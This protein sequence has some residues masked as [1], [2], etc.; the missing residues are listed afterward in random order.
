MDGCCAHSWHV[1]HGAPH[2]H[3]AHVPRCA[4]ATAVS[5]DS[6]C[7]DLLADCTA[8]VA[9]ACTEHAVHDDASGQDAVYVVVTDV[10]CVREAK[11]TAVLLR[12][13]HCVHEQRHTGVQQHCRWH[14]C[15]SAVCPR[16]AP[17]CEW[18]SDTSGI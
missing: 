18:G 6:V 9:H 13:V 3:V 15:A 14:A 11:G 5:L 17:W 2:E 16:V 8:R 1:C 4:A 10:Q 7:C 12:A